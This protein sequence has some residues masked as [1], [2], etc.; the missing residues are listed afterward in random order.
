MGIN[1]RYSTYLIMEPFNKNQENLILIGLAG[2]VGYFI[3][4]QYYKTGTSATAQAPVIT[5]A[6]SSIT[7]AQ[8]VATPAQFANLTGQ[9]Q[10]A[11]GNTVMQT[12]SAQSAPSNQYTVK[13]I[14]GLISNAHTI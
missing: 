3:W 12:T 4:K 6:P 7:P 5:N 2:V 11:A 8:Q 1:K 9:I 14:A 10:A 13:Y